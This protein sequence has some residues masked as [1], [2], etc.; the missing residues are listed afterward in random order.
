MNNVCYSSP[1]FSC[2][3]LLLAAG[4]KTLSVQQALQQAQTFG[5]ALPQ[6]PHSH[7][8]LVWFLVRDQARTT[9]RKR[10]RRLAQL[11]SEIFEQIGK[12]KD[13]IT[14]LPKG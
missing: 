13:P 11:A 5:S 8:A 1:D 9:T 3:P 12:H 10:M 14:C 4:P 7:V 6:S 2:F